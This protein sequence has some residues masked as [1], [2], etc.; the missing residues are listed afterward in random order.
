MTTPNPDQRA[1]SPSED[2]FTTTANLLP[3]GLELEE[4]GEILASTKRTYHPFNTNRPAP[5]LEITQETIQDLAE[6][7]RGLGFDGLVGVSCS[8]M[9]DPVI[10]IVTV[11]AIGTPVKVTREVGAVKV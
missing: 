7:A 9:V 10:Y 3:P 6:K 11:V 4:M 5:L 8:H 1:S 2:F